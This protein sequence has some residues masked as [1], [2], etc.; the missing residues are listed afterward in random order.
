[1]GLEII[2][3]WQPRLVHLLDKEK[4][5]ADVRDHTHP[6]RPERRRGLVSELGLYQYSREGLTDMLE[7][8]S[9]KRLKQVAG[10]YIH[11]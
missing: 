4:A 5:I 9:V 3:K 2:D 11:A 1:M 10:R 8:R 7:F 6:A